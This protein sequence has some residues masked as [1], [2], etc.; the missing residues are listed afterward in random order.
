[1][2]TWS[3]MKTVQT[4]MAWRMKQWNEFREICGKD[5]Q[6]QLAVR[7]QSLIL[8]FNPIFSLRT[9]NHNLKNKA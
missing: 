7:F 9:Q 2:W 3:I 5:L 1:M 8:N 4:I 6:L